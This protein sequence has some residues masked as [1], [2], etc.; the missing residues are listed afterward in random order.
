MNTYSLPK[1]FIRFRAKDW[2]LLYI[3]MVLILALLFGGGA[4]Q[5]LWSD[6][7]VE[8]AALPLLVWSFL[9]IELTSFSR[10]GLWGIALLLAALALPLFQ[11]IPFPPDLWTHLHGREK[12]VAEY[13]TAGIALPWIPISLN[14]S[15]TFAGFL[16]LLPAAAIFLAI[17]SVDWSGR[18]ML[19]VLVLVV[20]FPGVLL[21]VFQTVG[22]MDSPL[23]FYAITNLGRG[24][25]FFANANHQAAVLYSAIPLAA[26][27]IVGIVRDTGKDHRLSLI[28]LSALIAVVA[29]GLA[30]TSSRAGVALGFISGLCSLALVWRHHNNR[31]VGRLILGG[32]G[33]YIVA[34]LIFFQFGFIG[35]AQKIEASDTMGD[36]RWSVAGVTWKATVANL[37][38]GS[39]YGTFEPIYEM[40]APPTLIIANEYVNHAHDDWLELAMTGGVPAIALAIGFFAWFGVASFRLWVRDQPGLQP[41]DIALSRAATIIIVFLL[42][43]SVVDYPLRT[44]A[45]SVLFA[46]AC[47]FLFPKPVAAFAKK[48]APYSPSHTFHSQL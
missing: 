11:L 3:S 18:R 10:C 43:H 40:F 14:A 26:A 15:A 1:I 30:L 29:I 27:L 35:L 2:F 41:V 20:T 36:L 44:E 5:G 34:F 8:L 32:L 16:S 45:L 21:A 38:F 24:V 48:E 13:D 12:I 37:P 22:G 19:V 23:R 17:L 4:R 42:L 39:G 47:A 28:L 31:S 7:L 33:A 9:K 6:V 46:L 25:G